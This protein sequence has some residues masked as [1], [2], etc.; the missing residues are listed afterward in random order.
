M[1]ESSTLARLRAE[2]PALSRTVH[3]QPVVYLDYAATAPTPM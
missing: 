1:A 2:V 3:G